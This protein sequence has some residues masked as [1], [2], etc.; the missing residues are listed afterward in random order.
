MNVTVLSGGLINEGA[1]HFKNTSNEYLFCTLIS[2]G[3][4]TVQG[5]LGGGGRG[6]M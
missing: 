3:L 4:F 2:E 1:A 6:N 5:F